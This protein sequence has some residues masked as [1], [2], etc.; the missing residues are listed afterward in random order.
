MSLI[1][2][3]INTNT[4]TFSNGFH[5]IHHTKL[6]TN[7][8]V[9]FCLLCEAGSSFE[10]QETKG[11]AHLVE[12]LLLMNKNLKFDNYTLFEL[13]D[14]YG[15][16]FNAFTTKQYTFFTLQCFQ[17]HQL[18]CIDILS[19]IIFNK[20]LDTSITN[21]ETHVIDVEN[22]SDDDDIHY[23]TY[24]AFTKNMFRG[25]AYMHSTDERRNKSTKNFQVTGVEV[26]KFYKNNYVPS[27]MVLSIVSQ[28]TTTKTNT[29]YNKIN[30]SAFVKKKIKNMQMHTRSDYNI[31]TNRI[32]YT[33]SKTNLNTS[34]VM[35]GFPICG[36][37]NQTDSTNF[38]FC[39]KVLNRMNGLLFNTLRRNK[40]IA[41]SFFSETDQE[42]NVGFFSINAEC[43]SENINHKDHSKDIVYAIIEIFRNVLSGFS[44]DE[45][46]DGKQYIKQFYKQENNN[47]QHIA[48]YN[49]KQIF[50]GKYSNTTPLLYN[51]IYSKYIESLNNKRLMSSIL[52]YYTSDK[53][54]ISITSTHPPS[55]SYVTK[56]CNMMK[57]I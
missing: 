7:D 54:Q 27:K 39:S 22:M 1:V 52:K 32:C 42:K 8:T 21:K 35:V 57:S 31:Q 46:S 9:T 51:N 12:H 44:N 49:A 15:I 55:K 37:L 3:D 56:V 23:V 16:I 6:C 17:E 29:L 4:Y 28:K 2:N 33:F 10:T 36:Y 41:Y 48:E 38:F 24:N 53:L 26:R 25:T 20:Q 11:T 14:K 18:L 5:Y 19:K 50:I 45:L 47:Y 40:G 30:S 43:S 34:F 13:F